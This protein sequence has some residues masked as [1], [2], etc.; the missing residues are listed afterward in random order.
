MIRAAAKNHQD[1][2]V[3]VSPADYAPLLEEIRASGGSLGGDLSGGFHTCA[4]S[5]PPPP[6]TPP[7]ARAW[8]RWGRR[9]PIAWGSLDVHSRH[10]L[11]NQEHRWAFTRN[12]G[13]D[14]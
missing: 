7:S 5:R 6:M 14:K 11:V 10:V 4:P 9:L 8:R 1:V 12:G 3:V 13:E 2:A